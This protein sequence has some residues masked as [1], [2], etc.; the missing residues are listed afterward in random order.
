MSKALETSIIVAKNLSLKKQW[1]N[2]KAKKDTCAIKI[3]TKH[4]GGGIYENNNFKE[5]SSGYFN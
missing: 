2:P 4:N 1:E 3:T 5:I